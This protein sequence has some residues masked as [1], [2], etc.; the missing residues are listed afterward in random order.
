[1][2]TIDLKTLDPSQLQTVLRQA[3][4]TQ[5]VAVAS[6][7]AV[8]LLPGRKMDVSSVTITRGGESANSEQEVR[9]SVWPAIAAASALGLMSWLWW[10]RLKA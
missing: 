10:L 5:S 4:V 8:D 7:Q 6:G 1:V 3:A 9:P 2:S